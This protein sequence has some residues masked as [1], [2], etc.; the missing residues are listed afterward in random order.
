MSIASP[1]AVYRQEGNDT[2]IEIR[3][4]EVRQ[5][6]HTLDP[7][8]FREKDLDE[9]AAQY[10]LEACR[11]AGIHRPLRLLIHLPDSEAQSD[12]ARTLPR[13]CTT[14]SP[15]ANDSYAQTSC[16]CSA[17]VRSASSLALPF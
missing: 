12:A 3:L 11:E 16:E 2:L 13:P 17:T 15:I 10:L 6:F 14:T 5:L 4:R 7:A 1:E 8:P 9:D